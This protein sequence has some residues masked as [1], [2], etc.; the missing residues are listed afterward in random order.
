MGKYDFELE[1]NANDTNPMILKRIKGNSSVLEIGPAN[2][3]MTRFLKEELQ[4]SVD[5]VEYDLDSGTVAAKYAN[6][7]CIGSEEG[8]VENSYWKEKFAEQRY[9]YIILAD[10]LEHLNNPKKVLEDVQR[11][12]T[13]E[14]EILISVPNIAHNAIIALLLQ[15]E[16]EYQSVGLLDDTHIHFFSY[17]S[18]KKMISEV[19]L[20]IIEERAVF[21]AMNETEFEIDFCK[22][23]SIWKRTLS[24]HE[25]GNVYQFV[26][27]LSKEK[28]AETCL[29]IK[30]DNYYF[31][32]I[33]YSDDENVDFSEEKSIICFVD[34]T[35]KQI[36]VPLNKKIK[37]LRIDTLNSSQIVRIQDICLKAGN[38]ENRQEYVTNG[39]AF[40]NNVY[41]GDQNLQF[42]MKNIDKYVEEVVLHL[43]Y[44]DY[45]ICSAGI[46]RKKI[47][48]QAE[49]RNKLQ[50]SYNA[51]HESYGELQ[52]SHNKLQSV[53]IEM[54]N[55]YATLN[56]EYKIKQG[57]VENLT[58]EKEQLSNELNMI[59]TSRS[60]KIIQRIRKIIFFY[61]R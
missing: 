48:E 28:V 6:Q 59:Y 2:G 25:L 37:S 34:P 55:K 22:L 56:E 5:I 11:F 49:R 60:W 30:N 42:L 39:V 47:D 15:D 12:L 3:R 13:D 1:L 21:H 17:N 58:K 43:E 52:Q 9:D 41:F 14:G 18:I 8:N 33:F 44:L 32:K 54:A 27:A 20:N 23:P 53:N 16:F 45:E 38:E 24:Q 10:V 50:Q 57:Q 19:G 31:V 40:E 29:G 35:A 51:L 36:T 4:C 26:F 46:F 61:R 7:Y